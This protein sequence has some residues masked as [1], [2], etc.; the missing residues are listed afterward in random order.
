[1][2]KQSIMGVK[3]AISG[4]HSVRSFIPKSV[5]DED[6][7]ALINAARLAPSSLNS[8]PWRF[9]VVRDKEILKKFGEKNISRTQ[10]WLADAGA[11]IV[12]CADVAGYVKDSQASAFF[13]RDN[14]LI[15]GDTMDGIEDYVERE[16]SADRAAKFGAAAMNVG[17]SIS[18]MMLRAMELGLGTCWVGMYNE[19][20][21]KKMLNIDNEIRI[22]SLLAVGY[23]AEGQPHEHN[24]KDVS[25]IL[26]P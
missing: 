5:S 17:I 12:C 8:Q 10:S 21:V 11:I 13:Y 20:E 4:R 16:S 18:F 26:L 15:T 23:P 22:V 1:M 2:N 6:I 3:E 7:D 24:R 9:K 19:Q 25:E 14:E